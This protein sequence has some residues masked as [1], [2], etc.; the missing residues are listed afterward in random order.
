M[1]GSQLGK[2]LRKDVGGDAMDKSQFAAAWAQIRPQVKARWTRLTDDE[3]DR[4]QGNPDMLVSMI[5]EKYEEPGQ[6]IS[7]QIKHLMERLVSSR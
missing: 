1:T 6:A 2:L 5:A 7:L 4:V 3:L